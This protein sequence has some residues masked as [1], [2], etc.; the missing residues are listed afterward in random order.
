[1]LELGQLTKAILASEMVRSAEAL[2]VTEQ[3]EAQ[4]CPLCPVHLLPSFF[5]VL[6]LKTL[7]GIF[8]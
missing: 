5:Q 3:T 8:P 7:R 4:L 1:M 6:M 2:A